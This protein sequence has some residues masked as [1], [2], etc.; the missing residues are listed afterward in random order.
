MPSC[1]FPAAATMPVFVHEFFCSGAFD[2][3]LSDSSLAREGL[4]ML[5]AVVADFS[6][7]GDCRVVT[8]LDRRLRR[9]PAVARLEDQ[10]RV[11]WAES[12]PQERRLF[13]ELAQAADATLAIAAGNSTACSPNA[14]G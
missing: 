11:V 14:D 9:L 7:A 5:S 6:Q 1:P 10:A 3:D 4:A 12:P 13:T 2:G 8:T